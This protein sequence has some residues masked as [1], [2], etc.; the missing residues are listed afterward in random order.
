MNLHMSENVKSHREILDLWRPLAKDRK[1]GFF[2]FLAEDLGFPLSRVVRWHQR[3]SVPAKYW[4]R[5]I[6]VVERR[7]DIIVSARQLML[8]FPGGFG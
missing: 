5:L 7:F 2:P 1:V 8:A 4:P 3:D 6:E